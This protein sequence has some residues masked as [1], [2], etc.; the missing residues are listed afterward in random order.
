MS[1]ISEFFQMFKD[2]LWLEKL[3]NS[4]VI[5]AKRS[6]KI[7]T[8]NFFKSFVKNTLL[9]KNGLLSKF[10][11]VHAY[12]MPRFWLNLYV[13]WIHSW[14]NFWRFVIK[15]LTNI[16]LPNNFV[17]Y[18]WNYNLN[19]TVYRPNKQY[20]STHCIYWNCIQVWK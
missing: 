7:L 19:F 6:V 16:S 14:S 20:A 4:D 9:C 5:G 18:F 13:L 11:S 3:T 15:C 10:R 2:S 12:V 17:K 1:S 8:K